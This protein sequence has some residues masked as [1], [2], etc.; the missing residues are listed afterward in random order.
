MRVVPDDTL[1]T[2]ARVRLALAGNRAALEWVIERYSPLLLA[3]ARLRLGPRLR[4]HHDPDD[5][6]QE[7]WAIALRK[8]A[9]LVER[10][11]TPADVLLAFLGRI[12]LYRVNNLV[13][14]FVVDKPV[15]ASSQQRTA[16]HALPAHQSGVVTKIARTEVA[17]AVGDAL[18]KLDDGDRELIV[19]RGLE[20]NPVQQIAVVLGVSP[21]VVSVRYRRAL[22][23]LRAALPDSVFADFPDA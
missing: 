11:G 12:L 2:A 1:D 7:T 8:L 5:V 18:A 15:A 17:S 9:T 22:A 4:R 6:V 19:A 13:Q 20:H 3:Q 16:L 23:K 21:N 10:D 14:K